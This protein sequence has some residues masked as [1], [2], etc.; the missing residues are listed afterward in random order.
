MSAHTH[1]SGY[2]KL[3]GYIKSSTIYIPTK[4]GMR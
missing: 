4:V 2:E 3:C 1:L